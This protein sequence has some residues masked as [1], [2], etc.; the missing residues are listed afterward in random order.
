MQGKVTSANYSNQNVLNISNAACTAGTAT[1]QLTLASHRSAKLFHI[2][3]FRF[4]NQSADIHAPF[5]NGITAP[6]I[7]HTSKSANATHPPVVT[8][9]SPRLH[10]THGRLPLARKLMHRKSTWTIEAAQP[11]H[12]WRKV[13]VCE[14]EKCVSFSLSLLSLQL[15]LPV[16]QLYVAATSR[17]SNWRS[18][19]M[20]L[21]SA[22]SVIQPVSSSQLNSICATLAAA[23][24][25]AADATLDCILMHKK[26][27]RQCQTDSNLST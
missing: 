11:L 25:T 27:Y 18:S 7:S 23:R 2:C 21:V 15:P 14:F 3:L 10:S 20:A 6:T 4:H 5:Q 1:F 19:S 12:G 17:R 16:C 26:G 8:S 24:C 9:L 13:E 22:A